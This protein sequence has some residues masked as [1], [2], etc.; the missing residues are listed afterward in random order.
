MTE[1]DTMTLL[2]M[3][4]S[5]GS[6]APLLLRVLEHINVCACYT[7]VDASAENR[8]AMLQEI[9]RVARAAID[10]AGAQ[11][12]TQEPTPVSRSFLRGVAASTTSYSE[13]WREV[14]ARLLWAEERLDAMKAQDPT[15][16]PPAQGRKRQCPWCSEMCAQ[17][18][19]GRCERVLPP[20]PP[21]EPS[22]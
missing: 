14:A 10:G 3:N 13:G 22:V 11:S 21:Q 19:C 2:S 5:I 6:D 20:T 9:G 16:A 12:D 18:W 1:L 4:P 15:P 7:Q 8:E 17:A